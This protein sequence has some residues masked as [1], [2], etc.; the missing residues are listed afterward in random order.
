MHLGP[1]EQETAMP[2]TMSAK[3]YNYYISSQ[4]NVQTNNKTECPAYVSVSLRLFV[5]S[6]LQNIAA[7]YSFYVRCPVKKIYDLV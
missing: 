5:A 2:N 4:A 3:F 6:Q 1:P 7:L